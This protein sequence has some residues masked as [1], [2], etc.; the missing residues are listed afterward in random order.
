MRRKSFLTKWM[1]LL[2]CVALLS[3]CGGGGGGAGGGADT[4][5][6]NITGGTPTTYTE[7]PEATAQWGY[8][9]YIGASV[10][11]GNNGN[12]NAAV[13]DGYISTNAWATDIYIIADGL[14][15]GTYTYTGSDSTDVQ[16]APP[17]SGYYTATSGTITISRLDGSVGGRIQGT[18]AATLLNSFSPFD[19]ITV[20]GSFDVTREY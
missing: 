11:Y 5:S 10:N 1:A 3:S 9:P 8:D 20:S 12:I 2:F 13:H 17:S 18:F 6:F 16:Y 15:T 7:T 19:T 4:L 14:T